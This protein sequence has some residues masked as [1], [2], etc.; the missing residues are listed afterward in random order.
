LT[1]FASAP[2]IDT[3]SSM[4]TDWQAIM[5]PTFAAE[6]MKDEPRE[7]RAAAS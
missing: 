2:V 3:Q 1:T 6:D 4:Q 5:F 7:G